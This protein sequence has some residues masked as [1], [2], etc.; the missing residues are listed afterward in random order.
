MA[1]KPTLQEL[2]TR[3]EQAESEQ[4][5]ALYDY[6]LAKAKKSRLIGR[7]KQQH[8]NKEKDNGNVY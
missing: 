1:V 2:K 4:R 5:D 7:Y 6:W 8:F 3:A